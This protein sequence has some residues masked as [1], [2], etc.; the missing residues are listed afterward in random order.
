VRAAVKSV[1][2]YVLFVPCGCRGIDP[3]YFEIYEK[4][5]KR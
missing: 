4:V 3:E 1:T 5:V 2:G